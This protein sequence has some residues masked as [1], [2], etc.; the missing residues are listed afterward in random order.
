MKHQPTSLLLKPFCW[1]PH[2]ELEKA[3]NKRKHTVIRAD[4]GFCFACSVIKKPPACFCCAACNPQSKHS[5]APFPPQCIYGIGIGAFASCSLKVA[6]QAPNETFK[7]CLSVSRPGPDFGFI[8]IADGD[9]VPHVTNYQLINLA[10]QGVV[11]S[12]L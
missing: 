9:P 6:L 8:Q 2:F 10:T 1:Q 4:S 5:N 3:S 7:R 12:V 11:Q